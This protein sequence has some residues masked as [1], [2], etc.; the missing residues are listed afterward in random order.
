MAK[1]KSAI[2]QGLHSV[3]PHLILDNAAQA[4]DWYKRG[5]GAEEVSRAVGP[6][7]KIMHA[8][9]RIGN[10]HLY[11]NDAMS[12]VKGPKA[13][14][15][16]PIGLWIYVEDADALFKRALDAGATVAPT[17]MG[18]M[19]DQFWGDRCGTL[20][21][22][23]GYQWTIATR[24]EDLTHEEAKQRMDEFMKQF[25]AQPARG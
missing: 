15:G 13:L 3:T 25:A 10:S 18:Q 21:D 22:P 17:P 19:Q 2:P 20:V 12:G 7:G 24:K 8:Q 14:G 6:D 23:A 11:V 4:I 9:I 5:F 1:A 16:S